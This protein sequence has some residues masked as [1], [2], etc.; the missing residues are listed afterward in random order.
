MTLRIQKNLQIGLTNFLYLMLNFWSDQSVYLS[1]YFKD[2][3]D[4]TRSPTQYALIALNLSEKYNFKWIADFR[5]LW[6]NMD[7]PFFHLHDSKHFELQKKNYQRRMLTVSNLV[8]D[9]FSGGK[10]QQ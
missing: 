4:V 9:F 8:K 7:I 10:E 1:N 6:T 2:H 5:D 3:F